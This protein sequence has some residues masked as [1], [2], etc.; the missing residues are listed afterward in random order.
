MD[1]A[2]LKYEG[3]L[4]RYLKDGAAPEKEIKAA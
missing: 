3:V 2:V 4:G 1:Q